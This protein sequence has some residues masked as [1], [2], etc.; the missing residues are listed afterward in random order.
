M[1]R[2]NSVTL[3]RE[4]S[5]AET[6]HRKEPPDKGPTPSSQ[7]GS[8]GCMD[9]DPQHTHMILW[10]PPMDPAPS[11]VPLTTEM[12]AFLTTYQ[13]PRPD[14]EL[15]FWL[16]RLPQRAG[17]LLSVSLSS[18]ESLHHHTDARE[19]AGTFCEGE[20]PTKASPR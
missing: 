9:G 3:A 2:A 15:D 1:S 7:S 17:Q 13:S 12:E 19:E 20:S 5:S 18:S 4:G 11:G 16:H 6:C 14:A 8:S 10:P